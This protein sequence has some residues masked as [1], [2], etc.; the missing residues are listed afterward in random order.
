VTVNPRT[1]KTTDKYSV[2]GQ[3]QI[4]KGVIDWTLDPKIITDGP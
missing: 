2:I 1:S 3:D 4:G